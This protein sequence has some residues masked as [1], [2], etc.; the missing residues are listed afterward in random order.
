M[1]PSW[2]RPD[3]GALEREMGGRLEE[4]PRPEE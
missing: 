1:Q 4:Q 2:E 3:A